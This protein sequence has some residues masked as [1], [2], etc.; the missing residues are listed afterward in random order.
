MASQNY[1]LTIGSFS[2]YGNTTY[3]Y[4]NPTFGTSYG[5]LSPTTGPGALSAHTI[6]QV[7]YN[8]PG[9][10]LRV[11]F[12][13]SLNEDDLESVVIGGT[14]FLTSNA[15]FTQG[16]TSY[17][18]WNNVSTN[19]IG[20]SGSTTVTMNADDANAIV[21]ITAP[22][23]VNENGSI[24]FT[25]DI[26][27]GAGKFFNWDIARVSGTA[28]T[29][30]EI[31]SSTF[32]SLNSAGDSVTLT[33]YDNSISEIDL[34]GENFTFDVY[35]YTSSTTPT[36][37]PSGTPKSSKAWTLYDNDVSVSF[38][39]TTTIP[40]NQGNSHTLALT[41]NSGSATS[42]RVY[43]DG[44][45]YHDVGYKAVGSH[46]I[47]VPDAPVNQ[48]DSKTYTVY[49]ANGSQYLSA[50][51]YIVTRNTG[52]ASGGGEVSGNTTYGIQVFDANEVEI[53]GPDEETLFYMTRV[54]GDILA[55]SNRNFSETQL[56][57]PLGYLKSVSGILPI[58]TSPEPSIAYDPNSGFVFG[59]V[60]AWMSTSF[61]GQLQLSVIN[62]FPTDQSF[63]IVLFSRGF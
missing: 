20:T 57:L 41:V 7:G 8:T 28:E 54:T 35:E 6:V 36:G 2:A 40:Y 34:A 60:S 61:V 47:T 13:S 30:G 25:V 18:T 53:F 50:G 44:G 15:T 17:W 26:T 33:F 23:S 58:V 51:S 12:S 62:S 22:A 21:S 9:N 42:Y 10:F 29:G 46:T 43:Y 11:S 55:N 5:S 49:A 38:N 24:T 59:A 14:T 31:F 56:G 52:G 27:N 19:P 3:G 16:S 1:T 45:T 48:G 37:S 39:A 32:G 4:N 63:D